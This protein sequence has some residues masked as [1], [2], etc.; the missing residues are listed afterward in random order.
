[1]FRVTESVAM[2]RLSRFVLVT[3][4]RRRG[5]STLMIGILPELKLE[6]VS[7]GTEGSF[8]LVPL[9]V[10]ITMVVV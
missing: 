2:K 3:W 5:L 6:F 1:M 4:V 9:L 8:A 10:T 7:L